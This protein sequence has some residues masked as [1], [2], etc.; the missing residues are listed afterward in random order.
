MIRKTILI[1]IILLLFAGCYDSNPLTQ[2]PSADV[3][4]Y[5]KNSNGEFYSFYYDTATKVPDIHLYTRRAN[6][7]NWYYWGDESLEKFVE[8]FGIFASE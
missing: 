1:A 2:H 4:L 3:I 7:S 8:F 6:S 5:L